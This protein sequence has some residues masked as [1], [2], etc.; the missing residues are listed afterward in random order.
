MNVAM[1]RQRKLLIAVGDQRMAQ[2]QKRKR[3]Y[4]AL[5]HFLPS[6]VGR[7]PVSTETYLRFINRVLKEENLYFGQ[8]G[9]GKFCIQNQ[10]L[11]H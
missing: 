7:N 3:L 6:V 5:Q 2:G 11:Y 8:F 9:Y 10:R 1:S 4:Q